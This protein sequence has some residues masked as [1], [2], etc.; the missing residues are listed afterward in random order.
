[1]TVRL[2]VGREVDVLLPGK[3]KRK[4]MR[5]HRI[6][7]NGDITVADVKGN[8]GLRTV[9]PERVGTVHYKEKLRK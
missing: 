7:A 6:E 4:R 3:T 2:E 9:K 5:V 1:M 8:G